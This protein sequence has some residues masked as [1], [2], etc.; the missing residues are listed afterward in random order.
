MRI[1]SI[2]I[3]SADQMERVSD[4]SSLKQLYETGPKPCLGK[5]DNFPYSFF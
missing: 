1:A 2:I 5:V 4:I 3:V